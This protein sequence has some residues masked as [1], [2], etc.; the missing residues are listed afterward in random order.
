M[1]ER[2]ELHGLSIAKELYDLVCDEIMPGSGVDPD[3]FW[4]DLSR[5]VT[6]LGPKNRALLDKRDELQAK[7][8]GWHQANPDFRLEEYKGFLK[9]IGYLAPEA[10]PSG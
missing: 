7:I 4:A 1:N 5:I 10:S 8:D 3:R 6:D 2:V 9:G